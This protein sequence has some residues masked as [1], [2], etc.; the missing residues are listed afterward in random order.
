[1]QLSVRGKG[2]AAPFG[3]VPGDMIVLIEEEEHPE[4]KRNGQN[5]HFDLFVNFADAAMGNSVEVPI[6]GGRA[7]IKIE[8]GTQSGKII[9]LKGKG[10]PAVNSYGLGDQLVTIN[11]WTPQSLSSEEQKLLEKLR[12][13]A[14]FAPNPSKKDKGF[15]E[16]VKDM[17]K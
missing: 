4:L 14:N 11:V 2:N 7:R 12:T 13:S 15:F 3:G 16:Q 9:R 5:V 1:M 6:I 17:F 10:L 8:P